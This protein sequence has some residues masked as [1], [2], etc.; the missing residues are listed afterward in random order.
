MC[1]VFLNGRYPGEGEITEVPVL[2]C[3]LGPLYA[4]G[5]N[6]C[7]EGADRVPTAELDDHSRH[8]KGGDGEFEMASGSPKG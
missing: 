4:G 5:V 6:M 7:G 2:D 1:P 8:F 3:H